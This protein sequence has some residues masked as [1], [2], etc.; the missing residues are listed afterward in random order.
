MSEQ[1]QIEAEKEMLIKELERF[2]IK[3]DNVEILQPHDPDE[4]LVLFTHILDFKLNE[5]S[6]KLLKAGYSMHKDSDHNS[7]YFIRKINEDETYE[8]I[9]KIYDNGNA[10]L[11]KK[12]KTNDKINPTTIMSTTYAQIYTVT[13]DNNEIIK[14]TEKLL[15][16]TPYAIIKLNTSS[17]KTPLSTLIEDLRTLT[18]AFYI[19]R[20]VESKKRI[21]NEIAR[22]MSTIALQLYL[23]LENSND[24]DIEVEE[25][26]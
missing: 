25:K 5:W 17:E 8:Y 7:T 20:D 23:E 6:G 3:R 14:T 16:N 18:E 9:V 26:S 11:I 19:S 10:Y 15:I 4:R 24:K 22:T 2:G 21:Y 12:V 1:E 13:R